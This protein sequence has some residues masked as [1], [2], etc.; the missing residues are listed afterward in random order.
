LLAA[1]LLMTSEIAGRM[2]NVCI[3]NVPGPAV[4]VHMNG[5]VCV[6]ALG[7]GP[8]AD[9]MGLF[10][11]VTSYNG[12]MSFN[13]T[14]CRRTLPDIEFFV[15]C[16]R[17]SFTELVGIA[18]KLPKHQVTEGKPTNK[19]KKAKKVETRMSAKTSAKVG[20]LPIN[21]KKRAKKN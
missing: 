5:A 19:A 16:I 1:R 7:L 12:E 10:I 9:R 20:A 13:V 17:E 21:R 18:A 3:S 4:P 8:L 14:S 15:S 2:T 6:K 11:A